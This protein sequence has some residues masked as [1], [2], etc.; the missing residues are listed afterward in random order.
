[1]PDNIDYDYLKDL[2]KHQTTPGTNK[3]VSIPGQGEST[4]RAFRE[5]FLH[6][7]QAQHDRINLF[8]RSKSG[9]IER[10]LDHISKSLEQLQLKQRTSPQGARLPARVVERYAKI[11]ADV[12]KYAMRLRGTTWTWITDNEQDRRGNTFII[13]VSSSTANRLYQDSQEI[14]A[15]DEG[16]E[17]TSSLQRADHQPSGQSFPARLGLPVGPIHRCSRCFARSV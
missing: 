3:A 1:M 17:S 2:I 9:E 13:A 6:V 5:T 14:Q 7:L 16:Q 12:A 10:R 4:E 11:D 15:L 8:I